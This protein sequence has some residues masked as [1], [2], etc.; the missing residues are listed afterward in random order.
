M[1]IVVCCPYLIKYQ[2][3]SSRNC[4]LVLTHQ[5]IAFLVLA[6]MEEKRR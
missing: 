4:H 5:G 3:F 2:L 6:S 1:K